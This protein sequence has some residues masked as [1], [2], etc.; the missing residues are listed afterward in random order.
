MASSTVE[1]DI[2]AQTSVIMTGVTEPLTANNAGTPNSQL[3]LNR[4]HQITNPNDPPNEN[5]PLPQT[6]KNVEVQRGILTCPIHELQS[7]SSNRREPR[8]L[9]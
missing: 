4:D 1:A 2:E 8:R 7:H 6:T 5:P 3:S 9:F